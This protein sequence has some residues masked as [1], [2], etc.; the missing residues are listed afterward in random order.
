MIALRCV[1]STRR[2]VG[3]NGRSAGCC[4]PESDAVV[5]EGETKRTTQTSPFPRTTGARWGTS[6]MGRSAC[7]LTHRAIRGGTS[8]GSGVAIMCLALGLVPGIVIAAS[9]SSSGTLASFCHSA[10]CLGLI[11]ISSSVLTSSPDGIKLVSMSFLFPCALG[12]SRNIC[13][14]LRSALTQI[15]AHCLS[16]SMLFACFA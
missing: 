16:A 12:V 3:V 10:D 1:N 2:L 14:H 9:N 5:V 7:L 4:G 13:P 8:S 11:P 15:N 6:A